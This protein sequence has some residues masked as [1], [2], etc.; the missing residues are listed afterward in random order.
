[1]PFSCSA[2]GHYRWHKDFSSVKSRGKQIGGGGCLRGITFAG[3]HQQPDLLHLRRKLMQELNPFGAERYCSKRTARSSVPIA[4]ICARNRQH[5]YSITS[6]ARHSSDGGIVSPS[7]FA[8]LPLMTSSTALPVGAAT[9]LDE[10]RQ[11][12]SICAAAHRLLPLALQSP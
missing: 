4:A 11:I 5:F 12:Y 9:H 7:V 3:I 2:K 6:S 10:R 1:M 8:V